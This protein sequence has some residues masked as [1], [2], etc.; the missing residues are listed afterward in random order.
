MAA[1]ISVSELKISTSKWAEHNLI[2]T[3]SA[4]IRLPEVHNVTKVKVFKGSFVKEFHRLFLHR[5]ILERPDI[6]AF[7]HGVRGTSTESANLEFILWEG[8][9]FRLGLW[10]GDDS[11]YIHFK[12]DLHYGD[13]VV[14]MALALKTEEGLSISLHPYHVNDVDELPWEISTFSLQH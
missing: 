5:F 1:D 2:L 12:K 8:G 10:L 4:E 9:E 11:E 6:C 3:F 7:R 13:A 14:D